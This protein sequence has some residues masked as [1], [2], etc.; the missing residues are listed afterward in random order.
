MTGSYPHLQSKGNP[1]QRVSQQSAYQYAVVRDELMPVQTLEMIRVL[2]NRNPSEHR[3]V[4][5]TAFSRRYNRFAAYME[6]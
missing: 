4:P 3:C 6:A 2:Y 5:H 1:R